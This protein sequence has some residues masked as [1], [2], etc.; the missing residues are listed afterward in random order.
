[1]TLTQTHVRATVALSGWLALAATALPGANPARWVPVLLFVTLGPGFALLYPQPDTLRPGARLEALALAAPLS[2]AFGALV[3][4]CLFLVHGF[5][6]T[7]FLI[8][9]AAF[10]TVACAFPGLPLPAATRGAVERKRAKPGPA[11]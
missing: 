11:R 10:S 4:T 7:A 9:L 8:S 6:A 1:M 5:S 3:S 2:L